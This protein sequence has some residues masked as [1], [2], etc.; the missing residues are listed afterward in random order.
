LR[1]SNSSETT[2][3]TSS[4]AGRPRNTGVR[5][6]GVRSAYITAD[7]MN[8]IRQTPGI[9]GSLG[10]RTSDSGVRMRLAS[11]RPILTTRMWRQYQAQSRLAHHQTKPHGLE[12]PPKRGYARYFR[13]GFFPKARL[14]ALT[15]S[16]GFCD[17]MSNRLPSDSSSMTPRSPL[18]LYAL[19]SR[20]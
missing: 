7:A 12:H 9:G 4:C 6:A 3:S 16:S 15:S 17:P 18:T 2:A 14:M 20:P 19:P 10:G 5:P 1:T 8:V 13:L 11:G